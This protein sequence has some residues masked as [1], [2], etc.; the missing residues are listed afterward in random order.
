V[1]YVWRFTP[2]ANIQAQQMFERAIQLDP[3]Y[4][5][6]YAFLS[7]TH[8]AEWGFRWGQ[9]S[10]SLEPAFALAQKAVALDDSLPLAHLML[11]HMYL[12]KNKQH[13]QAIAAAERALA[14]GPN[15]AEICARSGETLNLVGRPQDALEL[16]EKAIRLNPHYPI[17]Y[18]FFLGH[19]Y[20]LT[21][22]YEGAIA[23]HKRVVALNP[24]LQ[25]SH[26]H[27]AASYSEVGREE[28]AR[29]A[30]AEFGRFHPQI[31]LEFLEQIVP[32]KDPAVLERLL[33]ALRK[34][35]LK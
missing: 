10:Q 11:S 27:L 13:E 6:A 19:T 31:S 17:L 28:E 8:W 1:E 15:D 14:L 34:A 30:V 5:A 26:L 21:R 12:W 29:A 7:F 24:Y 20:Y 2:E 25:P 22:Q 18:L 3:Q 9:E 16:I 32:Y 35:G 33:V 4:A 23:A